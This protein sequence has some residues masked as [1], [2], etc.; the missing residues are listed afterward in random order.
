MEDDHTPERL[1]RRKKVA[2]RRRLRK[3]KELLAQKGNIRSELF[4]KIG[5]ISILSLILIEFF[6]SIYYPVILGELM[7][8][9]IASITYYLIQVLSLLFGIGLYYAGKKMSRDSGTYSGI[10]QMDGAIIAAMNLSIFLIANPVRYTQA[11]L[12]INSL[13]MGL[14]TISSISLLIF[15]LLIAFFFILMG[16]SIQKQSFKYLLIITGLLWLVKLFLP[17]FSPSPSADPVVYSIVVSFSWIVYG[18][19]AFCFFKMIYE[20]EIIPAQAIQPTTFR[21]K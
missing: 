9:E 18:L 11:D 20:A 13:Y 17:A 15:G 7:T 4:M 8:L 21:L 14:D 16:T 12:I 2:E 5:I 3:E 10:F 1:E 19:T 6:A